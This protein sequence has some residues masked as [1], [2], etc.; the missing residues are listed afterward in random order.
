[1]RNGQEN[2]KRREHEEWAF[3]KEKFG[4]N[5][6]LTKINFNYSRRNYNTVPVFA[7]ESESLKKLWNAL[8]DL[9][10][11]WNTLQNSTIDIVSFL[12]PGNVGKFGNLVDFELWQGLKNLHENDFCIAGGFGFNVGDRAGDNYM[13]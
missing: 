2:Y 11:S 7:N 3:R 1:M 4:I 5:L 10:N 6:N 12:R 13:L 8:H 9:G